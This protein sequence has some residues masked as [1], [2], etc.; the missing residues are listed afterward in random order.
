MVM[1]ISRVHHLR[2]V[3]GAALTLCVCAIEVEF[4]VEVQFFR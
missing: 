3:H 2:A 4:K 1:A